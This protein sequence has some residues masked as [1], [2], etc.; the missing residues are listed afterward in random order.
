MKLREEEIRRRL[1]G[2]VEVDEVVS[3]PSYVD[4]GGGGVAPGWVSDGG[5]G[6]VEELGVEARLTNMEV[7]LRT[8]DEVQLVLGKAM[9]ELQG[10]VR[11]LKLRIGNEG[12]GARM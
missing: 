8:L 7:K 1:F 12:R 11:D 2:V 5:G 10:S 9:A 4:D 3:E 6:V